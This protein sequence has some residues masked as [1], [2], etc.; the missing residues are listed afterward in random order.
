MGNELVNKKV[1]IIILDAK[2]GANE[3]NENEVPIFVNFHY[4]TLQ[5]SFGHTI[6][7]HYR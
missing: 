7:A 3:Q 1:A 2:D 4:S 5:L 6:L